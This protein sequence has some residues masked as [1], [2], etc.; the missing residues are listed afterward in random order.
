MPRFPRVS[1]S[2]LPLNRTANDVVSPE[3]TMD[4]SKDL[5]K[6]LD[7]LNTTLKTTSAQNKN[8]SAVE[9]SLMK[10]KT[11]Q[12]LNNF[13]RD[14]KNDPDKFA[15]QKEI[16]EGFQE[17][18]APYVKQANNLKGET[19]GRVK[20]SV[21]SAVNE[22]SARL[23]GLLLGKKQERIEAYNEELKNN[24]KANI[25]DSPNSPTLEKELREYR[26]TLNST[27]LGKVE[28]TKLFNTFKDEAAKFMYDRLYV[29]DPLLARDF[30]SNNPTL[31]KDRDLNKLNDDAEAK[32]FRD[33]KF[34]LKVAQTEEKELDIYQN[35]NYRDI[36]EAVALMIKERPLS[37]SERD[38]AKKEITE[39][40]SSNRISKEQAQ[41]LVEQVNYNRDHEREEIFES[42]VSKFY[43]G[44]LIEQ[45]VRDAS[46]KDEISPTQAKSLMELLRVEKD[47]KGE[48]KRLFKEHRQLSWVKLQVMKIT[49]S[50]E[51]IIIKEE[52]D[53]MKRVN[54][55]YFEE[56][57]KST[58]TNF[59]EY[60]NIWDK[61]LKEVFPKYIPEYATSASFTRTSIVYDR[62]VGDGLAISPAL[63]KNM[64]SVLKRRLAVKKDE[65]GRELRDQRLYGL[66]TS[67]TQT[68]LQN[69]ITQ[70]NS[71][72]EEVELR[73]LDGGR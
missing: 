42:L 70:L 60:R 50:G 38:K 32:Y 3:V 44:K 16:A 4:Y 36:S 55:I 29:I 8:L 12:A 65:L 6:F 41:T 56:L 62:R 22:S 45:E 48:D 39:A 1:E 68:I 7:T 40:L 18:V 63:L 46:T 28:K 53:K 30:V 34:N 27:N 47:L 61:S 67:A 2:N 72:I 69:E 10:Q 35:R 11:V 57:K 52:L 17:T 33:H 23:D 43:D 25:F 19:G 66:D 24:H 51:F 58:P 71:K 73:G 15:T 13:F 31:F 14:A 37:K 49:E 59:K 20:T 26:D 64:L 5:G 21:L 9:A 54:N